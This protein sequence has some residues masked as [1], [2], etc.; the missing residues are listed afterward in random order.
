MFILYLFFYPL[1]FALSK[2]SN[3]YYMVG[4]YSNFYLYDDVGEQFCGSAV[5]V[6]GG[7]NVSD[8]SDIFMVSEGKNPVMDASFTRV[9]GAPGSKRLNNYKNNIKENINIKDDL[10]KKIASLN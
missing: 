2:L 6:P 5:L 3:L 8:N 1:I 9:S 7:G 4:I 10:Y